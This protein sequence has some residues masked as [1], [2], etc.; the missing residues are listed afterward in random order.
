VHENERT[1]FAKYVKGFEPL[2][3]NAINMY[4]VWLDT[5]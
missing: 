5:A 1:V 3:V 2:P 4:S